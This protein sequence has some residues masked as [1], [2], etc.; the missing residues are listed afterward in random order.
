MRLEHRK[1][2]SQKKGAL[3]AK[4]P[5]VL[6]FRIGDVRSYSSIVSALRDADIVVNAAAMKQVPTC[7]YFP[8]EA[9]QTNIDGPENII[10]GI[11]EHSLPVEV[12]IG[13]S[14]D[15]AC[16]PVSVMGMTK[17][18]QER[19]F[20]QANMRCPW[21]RFVCVRCGNVLASRDSV[22]PL[23]QEQI[24]SGGPLTITTPEMTRF[25]LTLD[26][27][28][29]TIFGGIREAKA[30]E[31]YVPQARAARIM[32]IAEALIG[33]R[34]IQTVTTGIRPGEKIHELL[35]S[36]EESTRTEDRGHWYAIRSLL[37][38]VGAASNS[39][40]CLEKEYSSA[41]DLMSFEET[42]DMLIA[43]RL[44]L[45]DVYTTEELLR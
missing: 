17:A 40:R 2:N 7:E 13:V 37:P 18:L 41:D 33:D 43:E 29:D 9:I 35:V 39:A 36:D 6:E 25:M 8:Y 38:E 23:F 24:R 15:K 45:D 28:V 26:D 16:K 42:R 20:I 32:T 5:D 19:L 3:S 11:Q 12:V 34:Q 14:T 4:L 31:V 21:T 22:I 10:R 44:M 27:A 30:G 1:R